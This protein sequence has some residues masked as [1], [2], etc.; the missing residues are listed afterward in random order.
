MT[1]AEVMRLGA[2]MAAAATP[3]AAVA[4]WIEGRLDLAFDENIK[5]E[6]RQVSLEAQATEFSSPELVSPAHTAILTPLWRVSRHSSPDRRKVDTRRGVGADPA[7]LGNSSFGL[8]RRSQTRAPFLPAGIGSGARNDRAIR[9][10]QPTRG[11]GLRLKAQPGSCCRPRGWRR[12]AADGY[13]DRH[14]RAGPGCR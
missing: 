10:A 9:C 6:P 12:Q 7:G 4:A 8:R 14:G 5:S 13:H 3:I 2:K 1:R 11:N